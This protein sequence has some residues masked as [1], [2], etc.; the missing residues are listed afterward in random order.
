MNIIKHLASI[1]KENIRSKPEDMRSGENMR[2]GEPE[3]GEPEQEQDRRFNPPPAALKNLD[4]LEFNSR[5]EDAFILLALEMIALSETGAIPAS[6]LVAEAA[7]TIDVSPATAKRYLKK[8]S[9]PSG[10]LKL[11]GKVVKRKG[12]YE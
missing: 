10:P 12:P 8:Y 9:A 7:F 4:L 11:S 3:S 1:V 5:A 6:D 2:S